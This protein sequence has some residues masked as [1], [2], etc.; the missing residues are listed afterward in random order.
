MNLSFIHE[1]KWQKYYWE[2]HFLP[3]R[4]KMKTLA[5]IS[6]ALVNPFLLYYKTHSILAVNWNW[7]EPQTARIYVKRAAN[8]IWWRERTW[9]NFFNITKQRSTSKVEK[10]RKKW[11]CIILETWC[12][13][14]CK[15]KKWCH[16]V[17][18]FRNTSWGF[19]PNLFLN[20]TKC[21]MLYLT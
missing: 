15:V 18:Q 7:L 20:S 17:N 6:N 1:S 8:T 12:L 10:K 2:Y 13:S 5:D 19:R 16:F 3:V 11:G 4:H 21:C 9:N 14:R